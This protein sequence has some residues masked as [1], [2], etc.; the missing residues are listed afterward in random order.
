MSLLT[1]VAVSLALGRLSGAAR[2]LCQLGFAVRVVAVLL[3]G[4]ILCTPLIALVSLLH[5]ILR[6]A[7]ELPTWIVADRGGVGGLSFGA[8]AC[9]LILAVWTT[10][11]PLPDLLSP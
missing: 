4:V 8:C 1:I 10:A 2:L 7:E 11:V 3:L 6:S 5:I 9:A